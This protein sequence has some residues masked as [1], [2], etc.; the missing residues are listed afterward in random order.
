MC[1]QAASTS[2]SLLLSMEPG[3]V[4]LAA[5]L[6]AFATSSSATMEASHFEVA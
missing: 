3:G 6:T 4:D 1:A 5:L 2:P